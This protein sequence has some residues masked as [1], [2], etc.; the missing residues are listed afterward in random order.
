MLDAATSTRLFA[1][2][3]PGAEVQ[4]MSLVEAIEMTGAFLS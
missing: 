1:A 2:L 3:P 4:R